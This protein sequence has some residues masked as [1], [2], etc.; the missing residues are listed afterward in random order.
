MD[1]EYL[2][3]SHTLHP[4]NRFPRS[5]LLL[6]V[7]AAH[8]HINN[9]LP[10]PVGQYRIALQQKNYGKLAVIVSERGELASLRLASE[11]LS[12]APPPVLNLQ[13]EEA[14]GGRASSEYALCR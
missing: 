14:A 9:A 11:S 2:A 4:Q 5:D 10:V 8:S 12:K 1:T 7:R 3:K 13:E 6:C